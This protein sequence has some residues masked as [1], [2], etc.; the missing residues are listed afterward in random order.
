ML[1]NNQSSALVPGL[2]AILRALGLLTV[3]EGIEDDEH[4]QRARTA[5]AAVGQGFGLALPM[6]PQAL[7]EYLTARSSSG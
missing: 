7:A 5:G 3:V 1:A 6:P 2:V 4:R